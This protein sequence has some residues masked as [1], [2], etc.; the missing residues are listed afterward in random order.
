MVLGRHFVH[1]VAPIVPDDVSDNQGRASYY[2][3]GAA[4]EILK[5]ALSPP[6]ALPAST[7]HFF[8]FAAVVPHL[9]LPMVPVMTLNFVLGNTPAAVIFTGVAV[10]MSQPASPLAVA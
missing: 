5:T 2:F 10:R 6:V 3:F 1:N 9:P 7:A 8:R 4:K